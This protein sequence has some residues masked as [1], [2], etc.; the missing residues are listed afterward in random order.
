MNNCIFSAHC[1]EPL[2]DK[3]CPIFTETS[4]LLERN[5]LGITSHVFNTDSENI[6]K[7]TSILS[8]ADGSFKVV[9]ADETTNVA[10][11]LT[12]CSIC[13]NWQGSRLHCNVYNLKFSSHIDAI[14][15]SWNL[16]NAPE[17]LEYEQI[18]CQTA[19][20]LIISNIDFVQFKD[21]QTQTLLNMIH[22]RKG[23]GLTTIIVS[24]DTSS[25]IGS[26]SF[27]HRMKLM[28]E[29]KETVVKW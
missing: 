4:Y 20:V 9:V 15:K 25:L 8:K 14:Q 26:G 11:I 21:F 3:S 1:T 29:Q 13:Q 6:V 12:Y 18:W 24:P 22:S 27:Y 23:E 16:K 28:L 19:K 17:S 2:C 10:N 7:A 5:G